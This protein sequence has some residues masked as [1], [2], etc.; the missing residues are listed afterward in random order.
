M[1]TTN[2]RETGVLVPTF[3]CT[4]ASDLLAIWRHGPN[5]V[6]SRP[7]SGSRSPESGAGVRLVLEVLVG[8]AG[9]ELI[10][11]VCLILNNETTSAHA[12]MSQR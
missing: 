9:V 7:G 10:Y 11:G 1:V 2:R 6:G 4:N 5:Q 3:M 12:S 8:L